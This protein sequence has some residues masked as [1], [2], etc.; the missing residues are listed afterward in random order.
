MPSGIGGIIPWD[1][2]ADLMIFEEDRMKLLAQADEFKKYGYYLKD[3]DTVIRV[4]PSY[5]QHYPF[6]DIL[7]ARFDPESYRID[8]AHPDVRKVYPN[9]YFLPDEINHLV[10]MQLGPLQLNAP[11]DPMR[12]LT[13][14]YGADCMTHAVWWNQVHWG[15][16]EEVTLI[17]F[18]PAAYA[19]EDPEPA[20]D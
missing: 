20:L 12:F 18:S 17:D 15:R 5:T 8:L 3:C 7:T 4:F 10:P 6:I 19:F 14:F 11:K 16:S 2:D 1:D 13:C 9:E